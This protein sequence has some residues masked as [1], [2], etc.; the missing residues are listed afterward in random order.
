M[1]NSGKILLLVIVAAF[2]VC[3]YADEPPLEVFGYFQNSYHYNTERADYSSFVMQQLNLFLRKELSPRWTAMIDFEIINNFSSHRQWGSFTLEEAWVR[4]QYAL[5]HRVTFGL[6]IPRFNK[7]NEIKNRTPLIP[8]IIRPIFYESSFSQTIG[9]DV[10]VPQR[11]YVQMDG[12]FPLG[13]VKLEYAAYV[14]NSPNITTSALNGPPGFD[15]TT[16]YLVGGRLGIAS[17]DFAVGF[18]ATHEN[19]NYLYPYAELLKL[20]PE[21]LRELPKVRLGGYFQ[22]HLWRFDLDAEFIELNYDLGDLNYDFEI[23][24]YYSTLMYQ[25]CEQTSVYANIMAWQ[26]EAVEL[27]EEGQGFFPGADP[28]PVD[29]NEDVIIYGGGLVHSVSDRVKVKGQIAR[30]EFDQTVGEAFGEADF[31]YLAAAISVVF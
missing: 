19:D 17:N 2:S 15:S 5:T 12:N 24:F 11:A 7:F 28:V 18:S 4:W 9:T 16:T 10:T 25:L 31:T 27:V 30:I 1:R 26:A 29:S 21:Q 6:Q 3:S 22:Y 20:D 8:Y 14:G 23:D 13:S